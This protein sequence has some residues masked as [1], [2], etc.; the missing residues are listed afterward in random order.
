MWHADFIGRIKC[1]EQQE[2]REG[3]KEKQRERE[4]KEQE[5]YTTVSFQTNCT[6][7]EDMKSLVSKK[8]I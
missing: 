6:L 7:E 3:G 5:K 1:Y 8:R 2:N 4:S